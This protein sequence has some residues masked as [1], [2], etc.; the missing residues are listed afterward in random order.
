MRARYGTRTKDRSRI[1]DG[2][3]IE[4]VAEWITGP[5]GIVVTMSALPHISMMTARRMGRAVNGSK[6]EFSS[7]AATAPI[8]PVAGTGELGSTLWQD[9]RLRIGSDRPR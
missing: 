1:T 3:T 5:P 4:R 8:E 2:T 9:A 7:N 6:V